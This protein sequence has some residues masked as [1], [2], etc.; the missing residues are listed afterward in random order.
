MKD[1]EASIRQSSA[2][3]KKLNTKNKQRLTLS[4]DV[5]CSGGGKAAFCSGGCAAVVFN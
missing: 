5:F 4:N 1:I 3:L 2:E